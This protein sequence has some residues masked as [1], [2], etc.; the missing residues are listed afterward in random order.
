MAFALSDALKTQFVV[1]NRP[2][3]NGNIGAEVAA[4]AAPDGYT[5]LISASP[6]LIMNQSIYKSLPYNAERDL[7]PVAAGV[8]NPLIFVV[9]P[10]I[11]ARTLA[12]LVALGKRNPGKLTY[13]SSGQTS[14]TSLGVRLLEESSGASFTNIPYKGLAPANQNL[15]SGEISFMYS[16]V[17]TVLPQVRAGKIIPLAISHRTGQLP[18]VPTVVEA[19]FPEAEV[20]ASFMVAV[21]NGT[22][23]AIIQRLNSEVNRLM[24]TPE[25]AARLDAMVLVPIFNTPEEFAARLK[26]EREKWATHIRRLGI[27]ADE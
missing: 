22:P 15:L 23:G 3:G 6:A 9:H 13:G 7:A 24:K 21:P 18:K 16:D 8:I 10:S 14:S 27:K 4:R 26:A 11:A 12:E 17:V 1:E 25:V 2:G 20:H 5:V 19:G